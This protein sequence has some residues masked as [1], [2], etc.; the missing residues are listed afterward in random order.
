MIL[1]FS[2]SSVVSRRVAVSHADD[3]PSGVRID[4]LKRVEFRGHLKG[5]VECGTIIEHQ[6][7]KD[8]VDA[9]ELFEASGAIEQRE[10]IFTDFEETGQLGTIFFFARVGAQTD[11]FPDKSSDRQLAA[12]VV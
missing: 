6:L 7:A 1:I 11:S 9:V 3:G 12:L 8:L 10:G 2:H 5:A 4:S